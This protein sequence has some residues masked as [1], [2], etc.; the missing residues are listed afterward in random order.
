MDDEDA[1]FCVLS[2]CPL[3][4]LCPSSQELGDVENWA[5][6]IE[7]DLQTVANS[8]E[9]VVVEREKERQARLA[10]E[11]EKKERQRKAKEEA[12][13]LKAAKLEEK[14]KKKEAAARVKELKRDRERS[15]KL[16]KLV[17]SSGGSKDESTPSSS[18][19]K[20]KDKKGKPD[21]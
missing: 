19:T 9:Y 18:S 21:L 6:T 12:A 11:E 7:Q 15:K 17:G 2:H 20:G 13:K 4:A 8:L 14:K 10:Q 16:D 5:A 1:T 3:V